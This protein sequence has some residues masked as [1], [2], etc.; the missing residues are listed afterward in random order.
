MK[1]SHAPFSVLSFLL[2][3]VT[4]AQSMFRGNPSHT[5]VYPGPAPR[6]FHRLKWKF[7][8]GNRIVSSPVILDKVLYFG[9]DDANV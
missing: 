2:T 1:I 6:E 8:T 7:P 5:G 4:Q 9:G 3:N